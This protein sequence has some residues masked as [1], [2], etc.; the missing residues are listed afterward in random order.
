MVAS[1]TNVRDPDDRALFRCA[2]GVACQQQ[3]TPGLGCSSR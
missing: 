1:I 3:A 2:A